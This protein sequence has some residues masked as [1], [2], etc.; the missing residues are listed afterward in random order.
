MR[1]QGLLR[2]DYTKSEVANLFY[3]PEIEQLPEPRDHNFRQRQERH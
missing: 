1:S 3:S 2:V